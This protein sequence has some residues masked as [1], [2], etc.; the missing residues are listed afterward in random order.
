[1]VRRRLGV[2]PQGIQ[3]VSTLHMG[4]VLVHSAVQRMY[5]QII[6]AAKEMK[7]RGK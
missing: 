6:S 2:L 3:C 7:E 4:G 5:I 1:M